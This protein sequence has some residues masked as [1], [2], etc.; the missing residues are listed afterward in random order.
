MH[1]HAALNHLSSNSRTHSKPGDHLTA[2]E[3]REDAKCKQT[4]QLP[5]G[6]L[7]AAT[8]VSAGTCV[9]TGA[10]VGQYKCI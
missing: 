6:M 5:A 4:S 7:H 3:H 2:Y 8:A 1:D 9:G 10:A